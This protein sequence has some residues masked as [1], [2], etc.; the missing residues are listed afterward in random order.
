MQFSFLCLESR[1]LTGRH[2]NHSLYEKRLREFGL[3]D[4]T[5][6]RHID[7]TEK[8]EMGGNVFTLAVSVTC[9][10]RDCSAASGDFKIF[11]GQGFQRLA[12]ACQLEAIDRP[13]D[14]ELMRNKMT[15]IVFEASYLDC[16]DGI[17]RWDAKID[18]PYVRR[19]KFQEFL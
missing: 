16:G 5:G 17:P 2:G 1:Y 15:Q 13:C 18:E 10:E 7:E 12:F 9:I 11:K 4:L 8:R 6:R 14:K 3:K 19:V